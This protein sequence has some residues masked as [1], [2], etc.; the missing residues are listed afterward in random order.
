MAAG[1]KLV[2]P[3][4]SGGRGSHRAGG[5]GARRLASY[6]SFGLFIRRSAVSEGSRCPSH[7]D[8]SINQYVAT[9]T[10]GLIN[11]RPHRWQAWAT[12]P[13]HSVYLLI[14]GHI[15]KSRSREIYLST[16]RLATL[17]LA[18]PCTAH[19]V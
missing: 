3:L 13:T 2:A 19:R 7:L 4:R 16:R 17:A 15:G 5:V 9:Q 11:D 8:I 12:D 6:R 14:N 18:I 1:T 10:H